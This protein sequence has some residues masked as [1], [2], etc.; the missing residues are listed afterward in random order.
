MDANWTTERFMAFADDILAECR[1][2]MSQGSQEYASADNKFDNFDR[3]ARELR[4]NER[5]A[6]ITAYDVAL[7]YF[8]KHVDSIVGGVSL[9][10]DMRGRYIDAINYLL[11]LAGMQE[12][13]KERDSHEEDDEEEEWRKLTTCC[14]EDGGGVCRA[15]THRPYWDY[16]FGVCNK[17]DKDLDTDW[18]NAS[19][20]PPA[21]HRGAGASGAGR[22]S[23]LG[24]D[25]LDDIPF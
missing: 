12:R 19:R 25:R 16:H 24:D 22:G 20:I 9:R 7:V 10:E 8:R 3:A 6:D 5:L 2:V 13:D 4:R 15:P 1:T 11:L 14:E 17:C 21:T 18:S 23:G